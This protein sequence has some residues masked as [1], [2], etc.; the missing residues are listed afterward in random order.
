M[1]KLTPG[2]VIRLMCLDCSGSASEVHTCQGDTIVDGPCLFYPFRLGTG[3]PK[4]RVIRQNCLYCMGGSSD[5]VDDCA[6][7]TCP[8]VPYRKGKSGRKGHA[9]SQKSLEALALTVKRRQESTI[10]TEKVPRA[11]VAGEISK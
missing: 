1:P 6:S 8:S 4:L 3:R 10:G 2:R 7:K 11:G 9:P 5:R